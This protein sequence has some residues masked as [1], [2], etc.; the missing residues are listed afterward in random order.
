MSHPRPKFLPTPDLEKSTHLMI[1]NY[2][3]V[4]EGRTAT[5]VFFKASS[6]DTEG[7]KIDID[8]LTRIDVTFLIEQPMI[9]TRKYDDPS[10]GF[11]K[12][13]GTRFIPIPGDIDLRRPFEV[14][15]KQ[16]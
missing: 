15:F 7:C 12:R 3:H 14:D 9:V 1:G 8:T 5:Q 4:I 2:C 6:T 10:D 13:D 11:L 16:L